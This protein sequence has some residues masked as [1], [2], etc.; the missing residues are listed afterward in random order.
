[1]SEPVSHGTGWVE[2]EVLLDVVE[3]YNSWDSVN[4]LDFTVAQK[5]LHRSFTDTELR[6]FKTVL[7]ALGKLIDHELTW[8]AQDD[9]DDNVGKD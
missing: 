8:R 2:T 1:M 9:K 5:R 4:L 7:E 3:I 6:S